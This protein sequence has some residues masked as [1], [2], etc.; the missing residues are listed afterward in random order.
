MD[1]TDI[2]RIFEPEPGETVIKVD[3]FPELVKFIKKYVYHKASLM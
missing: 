1:T 2:Q 3:S